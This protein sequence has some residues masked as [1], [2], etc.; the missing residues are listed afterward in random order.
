MKI[1]LIFGLTI[2]LWACSERKG[3]ETGQKLYKAYCVDC[4]H[5]GANKGFITNINSSV[6]TRRG[7]LTVRRII[8]DETAHGSKKLP[9]LS[10]LSQKEAD[11]LVSYLYQLKIA[12]ET[13]GHF[14]K[15]DLSD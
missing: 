10:E 9:Q 7:S 11:K 13:D 2:S 12:Y 15:T 5:A 14:N 3:L 6:L 1:L 8:M 4:H